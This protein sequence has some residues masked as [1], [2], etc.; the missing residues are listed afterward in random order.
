MVFLVK[1][2]ILHKTI[3]PWAALKTGLQKE[4]RSGAGAEP[5][6]EENAGRA[7]WGSMERGCCAALLLPA[8]A[9]SA[10]SS[11]RPGF[12]DRTHELSIKAHIACLLNSQFAL[13]HSH[14]EP[15]HIWESLNKFSPAVGFKWWFLA[16]ESPFTHSQLFGQMR[17]HAICKHKIKSEGF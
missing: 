2:S 11:T 14:T 7:V 17:T 13:S 9:L 3:A 1:R 15:E 12:C 8:L 16:L 5:I 10:A 6:P 4:G